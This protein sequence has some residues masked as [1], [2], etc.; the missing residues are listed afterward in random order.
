MLQ[1]S[2]CESERDHSRLQVISAAISFETKTWQVVHY[3]KRKLQ[4]S[5]SEAENQQKFSL[6]ASIKLLCNDVDDLRNYHR[7]TQ[8]ILAEILHQG[9]AGGKLGAGA[10]AGADAGSGSGGSG[11]AFLRKNETEVVKEEESK[12]LA[13]HG[14]VKELRRDMNRK[15]STSSL[16]KCVL[17]GFWPTDILQMEY[18]IHAMLAQSV[19]VCVC[20]CVCVR[21][22]TVCHCLHGQVF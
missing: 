21:A 20:V 3:I 8:K 1:E 19:L 4:R 17:T 14:E 5:V 18:S 2:E 11:D 6:L 12:D 22:A 15:Y 16:F 9:G 13:L 7:S 10:G